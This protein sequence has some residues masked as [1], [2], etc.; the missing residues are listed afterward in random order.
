MPHNTC[1][2][3][4]TD[5]LEGTGAYSQCRKNQKRR[6][7][8]E[9]VIVPKEKMTESKLLKLRES[10]VEIES[11]ELMRNA[12]SPFEK[13]SPRGVQILC[14]SARIDKVISFQKN[15][16][17]FSRI[18]TSPMALVKMHVSSWLKP[19]VAANC[20]SPCRQNSRQSIREER[21][22]KCRSKF[23][24]SD[25]SKNRPPLGV[26]KV[27]VRSS[28]LYWLSAILFSEDTTGHVGPHTIRKKLLHCIDVDKDSVEMQ[29]S[30]SVKTHLL[31]HTQSPMLIYH[32]TIPGYTFLMK[33]ITFS[34]RVIV[35]SDGLLRHHK[36]KVKLA[37]THGRPV[38]LMLLAMPSLNK[39]LT[40]NVESCTSSHCSVTDEVNEPI[41]KIIVDKL[42]VLETLPD[43]HTK[44]FGQFQEFSNKNESRRMHDQ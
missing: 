34:P 8:V 31:Q 12:K 24:V 18:C 19:T 13:C 6:K 14:Y 36:S 9:R 28:Q 30:L 44:R 4:P 16:K 20:Y 29:I 15:P 11:A 38:F 7:L 35:I 5:F 27:S 3:Q 2:S 25:L 43:V 10:I 22:Q 37:M 41:V 23:Q 32:T 40:T 42:E 21:V 33:N 1:I 39:P 26:N 17:V